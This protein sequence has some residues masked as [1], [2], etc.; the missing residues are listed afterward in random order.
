[1]HF[2]ETPSAQELKLLLEKARQNG[3]DETVLERLGVILYF[4]ENAYSISDT[5][6]VFGISRSTFHRWLELFDP[7]NLESLEDRP[8]DPL[9][10]RQSV[11]PQE[12]IEFIRRYRMRYPLMGKE[13]IAENLKS[14]QGLELSP[15]TIARIIDRECLYFADTPLHWKKRMDQQKAAGV[16][17][18]IP[19]VKT[20]SELGTQETHR[21]DGAGTVETNG[22]LTLHSATAFE[23]VSVW[24]MV[25]KVIMV[26]SVVTNIAFVAMLLAALMWER[27]TNVDEKTLHA[28]PSAI[29]SSENTNL[30]IAP[31]STFLP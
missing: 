27:T 21:A 28:A 6:R 4:A 29:E 30:R 18:A 11:I 22:Q 9:N 5:C 31:S 10:T 8:H 12:T 1:M 19:S 7:E 3:L 14:E 25:R 15:S 17:R 2:S 13:R 26:S 23:D 16:G 20:L 24:P